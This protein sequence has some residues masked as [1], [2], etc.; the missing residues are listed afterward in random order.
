MDESA[1]DGDEPSSPPEGLDEETEAML[2]HELA[3]DLEIVRPL[4]VG[5]MAAVYLAREGAL[6]RLVAVKVLFP[7]HAADQ[8]ARLRF[9]RESQA[10]ASLSHPNIVQIHRVGRLSND[11]PYFVMQYVKGGTMAERLLA[12]GPLKAGEARRVVAEVASALAA[13]HRKGI[14]HRDIRPGNVLFEESTGRVLLTDFGIAAI[15]ASGETGAPLRLTKTGERVG[16]PSLM[17]PEQLRGDDV[18]ERSDL[19]A[20]GLLGYEL[21]VGRGP[22][23][24]KSRREKITAHIR[25]EPRKLSELKPGADPLLED[26]LLRCLAKDPKHRPSAADVAERLKTAENRAEAGPKVA[27]TP[28]GL[29]RRMT[30]R[31]MPQIIIGYVIVAWGLLQVVGFFAE[32]GM[33]SELV[34]RLVLVATVTGLPAVVTGAWFHGKRGRQKLE[35]VEFWVFGALALVWLVTSVG[36]VIGW[37]ARN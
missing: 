22:Y 4:G 23:E 36:I 3:P 12:R 33:V 8:R 6:K 29:L 16:D 13:A 32:H 7:K 28:A 17:S 26:V 11:L 31:H 34:V 35:P 19:Y 14:V 24:A 37:A 20:L 10:V 21:A 15:L 5:A 25:Q 30:E 1:G 2:R 9:E 18:T 27:S